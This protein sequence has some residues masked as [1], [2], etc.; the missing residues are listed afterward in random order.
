MSGLVTD[1]DL[2]EADVAFPGIARFYRGL[3]CKPPTFLN[4]LW[5][6]LHRSAQTAV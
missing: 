2:D 6:F 3:R 1:I 4:L 5:L